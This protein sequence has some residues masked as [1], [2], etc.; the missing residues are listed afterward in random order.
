M[1]SLLLYFI[2]N[3]IRVSGS[4]CSGSLGIREYMDSGEFKFLQRFQ[5]LLEQLLRLSRETDD[6]VGRER[7]ARNLFTKFCNE[8]LVFRQA[9]MT[10]HAAKDAV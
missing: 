2:R 4:R 6:E 8:P 9:V 3:L 1:N 7:K 10:V 5:C